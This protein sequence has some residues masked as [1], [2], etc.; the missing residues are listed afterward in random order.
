MAGG[1]T[2][3]CLMYLC[4]IRNESSWFSPRAAVALYMR[5]HGATSLLEGFGLP[6]AGLGGSPDILNLFVNAIDGNLKGQ[7]WQRHEL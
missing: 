5:H 4:L 6:Q 7:T 2:R 3:T 1:N